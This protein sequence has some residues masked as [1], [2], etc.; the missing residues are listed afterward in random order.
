MAQEK[1]GGDILIPFL[2][3]VKT[4][5]QATTPRRDDL[6]LEKS[7][8]TFFI[9]V[10]FA[11]MTYLA[12]IS[13]AGAIGLFS[14]SAHYVDGLAGRATVE[15]P[16]EDKN[17]RNIAPEKLSALAAEIQRTLIA[18]PAVESVET[19]SRE[20][21]AKLVSPWLGD[22]A[23]LAG[24]PL[25][26]LISVTFQE[27]S[28]VNIAVLETRLRTIA[29][30]ARIDTHQGWLA[31]VMRFTGALKTI[32]ILIVVLIGAATAIAV[33]GAIS[34]KMAIH[35][36]ELELIHLMGATDSYLS[37]QFE[38][39]ALRMGIKGTLVGCALA[40][41]TF[42]AGYLLMGS[43]ADTATHP[44]FVPSGK[45]WGVILIIPVILIGLAVGMARITALRALSRM[46]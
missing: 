40:G 16:A 2:D 28:S 46:P 32:A 11:L 36:A 21:I 18:H 35:T 20:Q 34:S 8:G 37:R 10:L 6:A 38:K 26:A 27:G 4:L 17:G 43:G 24:L 29:P 23:A 9:I 19:L 15:I 44:S 30:A 12:I 3:T 7:A 31:T 45:G 1:T 41:L 33:S 22:A 39:Y 13:A 25:P 42:L 14:L 5:G